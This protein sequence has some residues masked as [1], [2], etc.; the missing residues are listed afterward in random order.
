MKDGWTIKTHRGG[1]VTHKYRQAGLV[2][3]AYGPHPRWHDGALVYSGTNRITKYVREF[4]TMAEACVYAAD[5]DFEANQAAKGAADWN[6]MKAA[7]VHL[8]AGG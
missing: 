6:A 7:T 5:A 8:R 3:K 2:G 1:T 4:P